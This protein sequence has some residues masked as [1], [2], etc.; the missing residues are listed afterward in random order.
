MRSFFIFIFLFFALLAKHEVIYSQNLEGISK[1]KPFKVNGGLSL[2]SDLYTVNGIAPRST[3]F[4]WRLTGSPTVSIYGIS[5]PFFFNI[6]SQNSSFTQ[7]FNHLG[8]SPTYKWVTAHIG[9]RNLSY[10]QFTLAGLVFMGG[11]VELK[12]G[13][14]RIA[15]MYGRFNRAVRE[16]NDLQFIR[17]LPTYQRTGFSGKVGFGDAE[18]FIDFVIFKAKDDSSSYLD[19]PERLK[20]AENAIFGINNRFTLFKH[21]RFTFDGAVSAYTRDTRLAETDDPD[22]KRL[23]PV[24]FT[25]GST[26][27]LSALNSSIGYISKHFNLRFQYRR[28]DQDYK[29]MGAYLFQTDVEEITAAPSLNFKK[30]KIRVNGSIGRQRDNLLNN[31]MIT[32][33]RLIG[34]A[35][36]SI[37]TGK[38]YGLDIQYGNYGIAQRAGVVPLNDT[39]R[40]AIANQNFNV[41]NRLSFINKQRAMTWVLLTTYQEMTNL[42]PLSPAFLQS[43]VIIANLN[44][45]YTFLSTGLN[46]NGGLNYSRSAFSVGELVV[47]GPMLG[48]GKAMLKNRLNT[49]ISTGVMTNRYNGNATG[50]TVNGNLSLNYKVNKTHSFVLNNRVIQNA[51]SSP[52]AVPFTEVF[53]TAGYQLNFY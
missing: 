24:I 45:N 14:L 3:P 15:A 29:S 38:K 53:L 20:P 41:V 5:F 7:P 37:N 47:M 12:P 48:V 18:N 31:K 51:S 33:Q 32:T 52:A 6:G 44:T 4:N 25:N 23:S 35:G 42:N 21:I 39:V 43:K 40:L 19:A 1:Q 26:Q 8:V 2:F 27:L 36:I 13:K 11:G 16:D 50:L 17:P 10:S 34:S 22:M 49:S 9:W 30:G 28:V 46:L